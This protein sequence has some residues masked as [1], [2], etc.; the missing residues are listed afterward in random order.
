MKLYVCY[1]TWRRVG[2]K[3][4][5]CGL[6]YEALRDAGYAPQVIRSYGLGPPA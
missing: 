4:H 3:S 5:P 1:G 2:P 6:A